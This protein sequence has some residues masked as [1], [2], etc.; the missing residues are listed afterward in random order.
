MCVGAGCPW[1]SESVPD[2]AEL[3]LQ[4]LVCSG[5]WGLET[6]LHMTTERWAAPSPEGAPQVKG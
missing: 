1:R 6:V 3:E 4:I 2:P 5:I